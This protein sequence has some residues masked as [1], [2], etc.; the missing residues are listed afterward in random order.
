VLRKKNK[1]EMNSMCW[2]GIEPGYPVGILPLI[3][4][5]IEVVSLF[6]SI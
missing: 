5:L 1:K 3:Q 6:S 2:P 4:H